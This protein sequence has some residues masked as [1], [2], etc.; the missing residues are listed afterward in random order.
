MPIIT[1]Q[2]VRRLVLPAVAFGLCACAPLARYETSGTLAGQRVETR[3]DS[4]EAAYYLE[5]YLPGQRNDEDL[6]ARIAA[7][8]GTR[9]SGSKNKHFTSH[10]FM[11]GCVVIPV[12][13]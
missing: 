5:S 7:V 3:V 8:Q 13:S 11:I 4:R 2:T 10:V 1:I 12:K 6:A 9:I